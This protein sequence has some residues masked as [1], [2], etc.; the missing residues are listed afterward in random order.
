MTDWTA[1]LLGV[2]AISVLIMALIQAGLV[3]GA[4]L[5][6]RKVNAMTRR[7]EREIEPVVSHVN[8]IVH[9]VQ[10]GVEVAA[11]RVHRI[12]DSV[13]RIVDRVDATVETVQTG[14]MTPAREGAALAA[15]AK[16]VVRA[17][18]GSLPRTRVQ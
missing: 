2:I 12:E 17:L 15:G 14:I 7:M 8:A 18:R 1:T 9:Q 13:A 4:L 6:V 10:E 5:A 16:A 11:E 3:I